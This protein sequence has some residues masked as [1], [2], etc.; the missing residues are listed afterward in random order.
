[1]CDDDL[2]VLLMF[3]IVTSS[4]TMMDFNNTLANN[5]IIIYDIYLYNKYL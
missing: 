3:A 4:Y 1:M 5:I 2:C